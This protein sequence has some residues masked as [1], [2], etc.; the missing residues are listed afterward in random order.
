M[1]SEI[2]VEQIRELSAWLALTPQGRAQVVLIEPADAMNAAAANALLKT[3]EEPN[4]ALFAAGQRISRAP[5]AD[6]PQPLP[7]HR[8]SD[9]A[10]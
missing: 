2:V 9:S 6:D 10:G 5:A 4:P 7:A 1:Y 3:L 8:F